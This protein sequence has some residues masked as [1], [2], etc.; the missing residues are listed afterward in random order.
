MDQDTVYL[1]W[2]D[3]NENYDPGNPRPLSVWTARGAAE[4]ALE[5]HS[6]ETET[7]HTVE[8]K[9]GKLVG[10]GKPIVILKYDKD[11]LQIQEMRLNELV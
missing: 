1:V 7:M 6:Q 11:R 9:G 2:Y 10:P 5:H 3:D 4:A 8:Y